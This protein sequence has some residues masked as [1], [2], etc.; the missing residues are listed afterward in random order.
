[1]LVGV[2]IVVIVFEVL[3]NCSDDN[4]SFLSA[5]IGTSVLY[6][7]EKPKRKCDR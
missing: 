6:D 7:F 5:L 1:M 4:Y 2:F 3:R